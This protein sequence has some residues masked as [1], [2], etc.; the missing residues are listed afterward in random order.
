MP[1]TRKPLL[2]AEILD[3]L[4]AHGRWTGQELLTRLNDKLEDLDEKTIDART[5]KRDLDFLEFEKHAPLHRPKKG[6]MA[7]Y[8]TEPFSLRNI[9]LDSDEVASLKEAI[10]I[11]SNVENFEMIGDLDVIVAKLENRIH[12]NLP[13]NRSVV[14]FEDHT[15]AKGIHW[16][17]ELFDA[18]REQTALQI[19]Y[20]SFKQPQPKD[21]VIHPYLLKEYRNRWWL[22]GRCGTENRIMT[23]GLD[24]I[25]AVRISKEAFIDN[26]LFDPDNYFEKAIGVSIDYQAKPEEIILKVNSA[27]VQH[28]ESKPIHKCQ[29]ILTRNQDGSIVIQL[30]LVINYE[31]KATILS[32]GEHIEVVAPPHLINDIKNSLDKALSLYK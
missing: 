8:Y 15:H 23:L 18:I 28:V 5:L 10:T 27:S 6:S 3:E 24:R 11:L 17:S 30:H 9:P 13:A 4:L 2:R 21:Y 31:L 25:N 32:F 19:N 7:Y 22:L 1:I 29:K 16:F 20:Q 12:T 14:Q 26:D